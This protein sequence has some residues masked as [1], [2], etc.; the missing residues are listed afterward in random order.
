MKKRIL[1]VPLFVVFLLT[2]CGGGEAETF[3]GPL[4]EGDVE[5]GQTTYSQL[6][7]AC[8]GL[9]GEGVEGLGKSIT[10]SEFV[11]TSSDEELVAFILEGRDIDHPDNTTGV[12][13]PPKGGN[14]ALK[15]QEVANLIAYMRSIQE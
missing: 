13:M 4:P 5:A 7:V 12:A 14:P 10:T 15:M 11:A 3:D 2:A 9:N 6:C 8:H 1:I